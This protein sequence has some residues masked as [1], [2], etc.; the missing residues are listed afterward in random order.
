M[1]SVLAMPKIKNKKVSYPVDLKPSEKHSR[2][3]AL[4]K[5]TQ[6]L[7]HVVEEVEAIEE[8]APPI[9]IPEPFTAAPDA[10]AIPKA[11]AEQNHL[12]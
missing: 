4:K 3:S 6:K 1:R 8:V 9:Y 11:K 7:G 2:M 10:T 12:S 5:V